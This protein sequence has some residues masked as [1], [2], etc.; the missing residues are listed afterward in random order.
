MVRVTRNHEGNHATVNVDLGI[1][2]ST[3]KTGIT[4]ALL[5][6]LIV[7]IFL[8]R[9]AKIAAA[10][11]ILAFMFI[12]ITTYGVGVQYETLGPRIAN[13]IFPATGAP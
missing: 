1:F 10:A 12:I 4:L 3:L 7:G 13:A 11:G 8:A 9:K 2:E 5:A 6:V